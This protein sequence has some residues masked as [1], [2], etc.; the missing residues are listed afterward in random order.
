MKLKPFLLKAM[1][2]WRG[3]PMTFEAVCDSAALVFDR[4]PQTDVKLALA[5]LEHEGYCAG[6]K[7]DLLDTTTWSL[8]DKGR[9]AAA[10]LI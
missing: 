4:L 5:E 2:R 3:G 10:Q 7:N 6:M 8:T 9:H 1:L